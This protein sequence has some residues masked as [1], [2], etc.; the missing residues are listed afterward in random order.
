MINL[1]IP[2]WL[3]KR[4]YLTPNKEAIVLN[5]NESYTFYELQQHAKSFATF[6]KHQGVKQGDHIGLLSTNCYE[7]VVT[8]HALHYIGAV[9]FLLNVRLKEDELLFQ[10]KDGNIQTVIHHPNLTEKVNGLK[11]QHELKAIHFNELPRKGIKDVELIDEMNLDDVSHIIYTSGTT[12]NPK[13]VQLTYGNHWWSATASA[14]NLGLHETDRWLLSLPLFHV[15]GLSILYRSVIYGMPIHLHEQYDLEAVYTDIMKNGVTIVS[16]VT[17]MLEELVNRLQDDH[18]PDTLRCMLLGGGPASKSLLEKCRDKRIPVY[19]SYGMT[20]TASQFCT[21]DGDNMLTKIG[22]AGKPLFPGQLKIV[23]NDRECSIR[24]VGEIV[25]KGPSV[26]KG[27]W[28]R[29]DANESSF[30]EEWFKT[31]DLG[32]FDE[33]GYLYV[34]D[35]RKDLIISG[36]ENVYPAEIESV[37]KGIVGIK[38][39]GVVGVDDDKWGQVPVAFIVP[40]EPLEKETIIEECQKALA[41]YKVPKQIMFVDELPRNASKKLMRHKLIDFLTKEGE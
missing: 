1:H 28:N 35:R 33:D 32:Y 18:F 9:T 27:Y 36:G 15:G 7:M 19:Q 16:V 40:S 23:K 21:L 39:A 37:L 30:I 29:K 26:T 5:Q 11:K 25:V 22:S 3:D 4:A 14:L 41:N 2:N 8:I 10:L 38:D 20:E 34:V 17:V 31:G 6:L 24:E 13:G 12:G